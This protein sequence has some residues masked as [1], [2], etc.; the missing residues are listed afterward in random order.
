MHIQNFDV[1]PS[2]KD[3]L[4]AVQSEE[5]SS[6]F[7]STTASNLLLT[8]GGLLEF[9]GE[10]FEIA[11]EAQIDLAKL[12][13]IPLLGNLTESEGRQLQRSLSVVSRRGRGA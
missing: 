3:Y 10:A 4:T 8:A 7:R 6:E 5:E 13:R 1:V 12:A 11:A 9:D 2:A